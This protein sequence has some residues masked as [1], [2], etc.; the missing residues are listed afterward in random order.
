[1]QALSSKG[2][3]DINAVADI[4][5]VFT[6]ALPNPHGVPE[7][8]LLADLDTQKLVRKLNGNKNNASQSVTAAAAP[9]VYALTPFAAAAPVGSYAHPGPAAAPQQHQVSLPLAGTTKGAPG[10]K[11]TAAKPPLPPL[12][13]RERSDI[14]IATRQLQAAQQMAVAVPGASTCNSCTRNGRNPHHPYTTCG[15]AICTR[16]TRGGHMA[17]HCPY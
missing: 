8:R 2:S 3:S 5:T 16:C 9:T 1:M 13:A 15:F 4:T 17:N 14:D 11:K 12:S 7:S 6:K 10:A